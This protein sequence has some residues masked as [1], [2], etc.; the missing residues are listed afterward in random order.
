M[1]ANALSL[2]FVPSNEGLGFISLQFDFG[3]GGW[4]GRQANVMSPQMLL[5]ERST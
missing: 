1:E 2:G 5:R 3:D 4:N